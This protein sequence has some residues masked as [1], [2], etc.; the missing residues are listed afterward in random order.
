IYYENGKYE[1]SLT[2]FYEL[3]ND[4]SDFERA[5]T[6]II[7]C[8]LKMDLNDKAEAALKTLI[9]Q[10]PESSFACEALLVLA[11]KIHKRAAFEWKKTVFIQSE[12]LRLK[13][14]QQKLN[15]HFENLKAGPDS[16]KYKYADHELKTLLSRLK[17]ENHLNHDSIF[18]L[19]NKADKISDLILT[20]YKTGSFQDKAFS[21]NREK[22]LNFL[23]SVIIKIQSGNFESNSSAPLSNGIHMNR[24]KI[25]SVLEDVSDF[26]VINQIDKYRWEKEY[27]DNS[28]KN[29]KR[30]EELIS[31][32]INSTTDSIIR[33]DLILKKNL[34]TR[35]LDSVVAREDSVTAR[36][37]NSLPVLI[38]KRLNENSSGAQTDYFKYQLGELYYIIDNN[39]Y[40]RTYDKY[41]LDLSH[42]NQQMIAYRQ[43][44]L[45][46]MPEKPVAPKLNHSR[47][48]QQF[49]EVIEGNST[50]E[51]A[52]HCLYSLGWCYNDLS[53][54]DSAM[55]YLETLVTLYPGNFYTPQAWMYCGE[56]YFDKGK[57]DK[58]INCYQAV[59]RYP[60]SEWFD[61]ALYKLAWSQYRISNPEKAISSFLALVDLGK[62]G[63]N[64]SS[65][66]EKES[67]DY[68]A[69]SFSETDITGEKG[70]ERA[71]AFA[72]KLGEM[73]KGCMILSR[74]A[75]VFREQGRYEL[76]AK[77]YSSILSI[78]P[79]YSMNAQIEVELI[80]VLERQGSQKEINQL[81]IAL[82]QRYNRN[83]DWA[84]TQNTESVR[85]ADSIA[86]A[87]LYSAAIGFHQLAIQK[88]DNKFYTNALDA[89]SSFIKLYPAAPLANECHYNLAEINFSLGNYR[90]AA[91]EYMAVSRRYPDS[92]YRENAAWNAIVASQNFLKNELQGKQPK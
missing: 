69:I 7:W 63:I 19:Y 74:L 29:H 67:M 82:F 51:F 26:K 3:L 1:A 2:R 25:K 53:Q 5:L 68:I 50:S 76:S 36:Y 52:P 30:E 34:I 85:L 59:M 16:T 65:L 71:V 61:E 66:L 57:L 13:A 45:T 78:Y 40:A 27:F 42:Y 33:R 10:S 90:E 54:Y 64:G 73:D 17:T 91:E 89:Y 39:I 43:G 20:H 72:K 55:Y 6:G 47:S 31:T 92:K 46:N 22:I 32:K 37:L 21:N 44:E 35:Q 48:I 77:T 8:Y 58:A 75:K 86:A 9:N 83:S 49:K 24:I 81:R 87:Q 11:K 14:L 4:K 88:T 23:D 80:S 28:K 18:T 38:Q 41:E 79:N 70:L 15:S 56:Y 12:F 60:E 62:Y 84:K